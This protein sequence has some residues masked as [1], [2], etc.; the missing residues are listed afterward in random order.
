MNVRGVS[1]YIRLHLSVAEMLYFPN[2]YEWRG[3]VR[4]QMKE[5]CTMLAKAPMLRSLEIRSMDDVRHSW[6]YWNLQE[7]RPL[8]RLI[9]TLLEPLLD[10]PQEPSIR[11]VDNRSSGSNIEPNMFQLVQQT[12]TESMTAVMSARQAKCSGETVMGGSIP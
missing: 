1:L 3:M 11:L 5:I 8:Q 9:I 2:T 4:S 12:F 10:L 6:M 7:P